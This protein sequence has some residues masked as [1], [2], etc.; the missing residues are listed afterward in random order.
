MESIK[1][2]K[3]KKIKEMKIHSQGNSLSRHRTEERFKE[4]FLNNY[5]W[6]LHTGNKFSDMF[7]SWDGGPSCL[8]IQVNN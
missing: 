2:E 7:K 5:Y 3:E 1:P 8:A 4:T 6:T